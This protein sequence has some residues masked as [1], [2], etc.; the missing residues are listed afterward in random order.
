MLLRDRRRASEPNHPE[1]V[2][3]ITPRTNAAVITPAENMLAA[4]S[5]AEPF[6]LEITATAQ[7][8]RFV[9][10]AGSTPMRQHLEDQ[11]GVAYPQAELRRLDVEHFPG[12]D[13]AWRHPDEQVAVRTFSLRGPAYLPLRMFGDA[14]V[15]ADRAA[16]ADPVLGLL[17]ALGD[18]P[19]GWRSL[20][21]VVLSPAPDDWCRDFMRLAVEHPLASERAAGHA[22]T[23]LAPVFML[24]GLLV[25]GGLAFQSYQWFLAGRWLQLGLLGTGVVVVLP[26]AIWLARRL[27]RRQIY[28][29]RLVQEK[30]SRTA[31]LSEIRV[32]V[33]APRDVSAP[34]LD[35]YL[36][37]LAS[38]YRQFNLASGNGLGSRPLRRDDLDLRELHLL[39][40]A[41]STPILN[42]RELAGLW[43]L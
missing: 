2:E 28:D 21:Q 37:R 25:A 20:S 7:A 34:A 38:A 41:R 24:A 5:L 39:A 3:I 10:R 18:L 16:Q 9:V 15:A 32:A 13:P 30:I 23:S 31:F 1:L 36:T 42:T 6:S 29:M 12:L 43:H 27:L 11:L 22:D 8:R 26:S 35:T 33:F 19:S 17:G 4:I 14:E 40:P